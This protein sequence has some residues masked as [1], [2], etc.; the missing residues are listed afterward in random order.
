MSLLLAF[1]TLALITAAPTPPPVKLAA[2]GFQAVQLP[3]DVVR[4]YSEH[5]AQQLVLQGLGVV[6][7]QQISA[8]VGLERQK[9]LVGCSDESCMAEL[10]GALGVDAM[11]TGSI[12][13]LGAAYQVNVSIISAKDGQV[14]SA[15]SRKLRSEE[16]V[17]DELTAAARQMGPQVLARL[18]RPPGASSQAPVT[19]PPSAEASTAPGHWKG[20]WWAPVAAGVVSAGVGGF[21]LYRS[22]REYDAV[23]AWRQ[24]TG[25]V[26]L[27]TLEANAQSGARAQQWGLALTGVGAAALG[28]GVWMLFTQPS[29]PQVLVG[30]DSG[31]GGWVGLQGVLP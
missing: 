19:P 4:F 15:H 27:A 5:F 26:S 1:T 23:T 8:L 22:A 25:T 21:F 11:I 28:T 29:T 30:F 24:Q 6:T 14:L 13:K 10:A 12:G 2:P 16:E 18:Q 17:L 9:Q 31:G 7:Q 3:E 20:L